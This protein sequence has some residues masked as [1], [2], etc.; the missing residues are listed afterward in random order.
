MTLFDTLLLAGAGLVGGTLS[1]VVGGA[2]LFTFPALLATG[3]PPVHA[4]A[5]NMA[6]MVP[7]NFIAAVSDGSRLPRFDRAFVRLL[8]ASVAGALV[9]AML[10]LLTPERMFAVLVP[11][12][13]GFATML[14][15]FSAR[16]SAWLRARA[17]DIVARDPHASRHSVGALVPVSIYGGYFGAGVGVLILAVL[18]VGTA[19][20]YRAANVAKNLVTS[21]NSVAAATLFIAQGIVIWPQTLA[22]MSGAFVGGLLGS[23]LARSLPRELMRVM[24]VVVGAGLTSIFA[25][26]YWF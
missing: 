11:L 25:C 6:A 21:L 23:W 7:C 9:G 1:A 12:L 19:G 22:L 26:R 5:C 17:A 15:G 3:L 16:I 4:A 2:A 20:D 18:S 8:L 10:L 24:I 13:L 14:F